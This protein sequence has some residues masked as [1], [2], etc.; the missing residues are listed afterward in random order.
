MGTQD[1]DTST[2]P[3]PFESDVPAAA[4]NLALI[5][6]AVR[7]KQV[8]LFHTK[9]AVLDSVSVAHRASCSIDKE[10]RFFLHVQSGGNHQI[11]LLPLCRDLV[12]EDNNTGTTKDCND[13]IQT[14][15]WIPAVSDDRV[16]V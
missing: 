5:R 13:A 4:P 7:V 11:E 2:G 9:L 16:L 14:G 8:K 12:G 1:N 3:P 10:E 15:R 6:L